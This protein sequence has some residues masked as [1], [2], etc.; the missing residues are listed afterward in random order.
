MKKQGRG[1]S[2][3]FTASVAGHR[4]LFPMNATA[5]NVSKGGVLQLTKTLAAE[6]AR[7]GIRVNSI[8]PGYMDTSMTQPFVGDPMLKL[9]DVWMERNPMGRMGKA[10]ELTGPVIL[11][12]SKGGRYMTGADIVVDGT[13][14]ALSLFFLGNLADM[15]R[16]RGNACVLSLRQKRDI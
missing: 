15:R 5:Y 8:S 1:G 2:I 10:N 9:K 13:L 7:Y 14:A 3:V 16:N 6:W 12:C 11:L 4:A